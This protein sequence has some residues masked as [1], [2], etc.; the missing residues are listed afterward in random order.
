[1]DNT[2]SNSP[3]SLK[4]THKDRKIIDRTAQLDKTN[5][6]NLVFLMIDLDTGETNI[7]ES[8]ANRKS[9]VNPVGKYVIFYPSMKKAQQ[10]KE[11]FDRRPSLVGRYINI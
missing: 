3:I 1:M 6:S 8:P 5:V 4:T 2:P 11:R 7:E 9:E 10:V